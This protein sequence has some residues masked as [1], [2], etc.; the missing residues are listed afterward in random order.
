MNNEQIKQPEV[1]Q[2]SEN[3]KSAPNADYR[4][5]TDFIFE[6][7]HLRSELKV[8]AEE[9][10]RQQRMLSVNLKIGAEE[11]E[12][13][14][15]QELKDQGLFLEERTGTV[16]TSQDYLFYATYISKIEKEARKLADS[17]A[18]EEEKKA[19]LEL[20]NECS[21]DV[22][23][24]TTKLIQIAKAED[25]RNNRSTEYQVRLVENLL[26][27]GLIDQA[28]AEQWKAKLQDPDYITL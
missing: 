6:E 18:N 27:V 26:K 5:E 11:I 17:S 23:Q 19:A 12:T 2:T 10:L 4:T 14:T 22:F 21:S 9:D 3:H 1:D 7:K 16:E 13:N 24:Y 8:R 28:E 15:L 20:A 25:I